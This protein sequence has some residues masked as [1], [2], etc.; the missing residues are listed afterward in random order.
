MIDRKCWCEGFH[1][2]C[3]KLGPD[4]IIL[5][6]GFYQPVVQCQPG[7]SWWLVVRAWWLPVKPHQCTSGARDNLTSTRTRLTS[8][9][10][11]S[12]SE[13]MS[14]ERKCDIQQHLQFPGCQPIETHG[15]WLYLDIKIEL[16]PSIS[17]CTHTHTYLDTSYRSSW[18]LN[19]S[20]PLCPSSFL[21]HN[22][23]YKIVY[24]LLLLDISVTWCWK[25]GNF[26][27]SL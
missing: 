11:S 7:V 27:D 3:P 21:G 10:N 23:S 14:S 18:S 17:C 4:G 12:Q 5:T 2:H 13:L 26:H 24:V 9:I 16:S 20:S 15:Q 19:S 1:C 6:R 8:N 25:Y 22:L